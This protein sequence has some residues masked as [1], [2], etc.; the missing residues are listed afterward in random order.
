MSWWCHQMETFSVFLALWCVW[1]VCVC[2]RGVHWSLVNCPHKGQWCRALI[3]SLI[4]ASINGLVSNW[5]VSDLRRH[6]AYYDIT[7]MVNMH[8][9]PLYSVRSW[10]NDSCCIFL[11]FLFSSCSLGFSLFYALL[12]MC[13]NKTL[14]F[15]WMLTWF[16]GMNIRPSH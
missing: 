8:A 16:C 6:H 3:F 12:Y 9:C 7:V 2:G 10:N 11:T 1:C 4:C 15:D 13:Y 5:N 14:L